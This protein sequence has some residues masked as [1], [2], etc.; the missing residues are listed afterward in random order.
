ML[1]LNLYARV[2]F[3]L[4][5]FAR[6]TAGAARIRLSLRPL[7]G[8]GGIYP[9]QNSRESCGEI[10]KPCLP[11]FEIRNPKKREARMSEAKSGAALAALPGCRFAHPGY[12]VPPPQLKPVDAP[13]IAIPAE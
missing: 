6:E 13:E 5:A 4:C 10:A 11:L 2:H 1:P 9:K 12:E 8:E 3:L 7:I